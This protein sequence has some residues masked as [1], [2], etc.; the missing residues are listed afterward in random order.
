MTR[1]VV[2]FTGEE[3]RQKT[4][5]LLASEGLEAAAVCACG[6]EVIPHVPQKV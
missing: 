1:I 5:R 6:A 3:L 2:A 4:L